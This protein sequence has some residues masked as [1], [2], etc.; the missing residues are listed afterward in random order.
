MNHR[1]RILNV[2]RDALKGAG[3][4]ADDRRLEAAVAN[5]ATVW[6]GDVQFYE[7]DRA[8]LKD[9]IR[10][11]EKLP[12]VRSWLEGRLYTE[13]LDELQ[14]DDTQTH[15][16]VELTRAFALSIHE[17]IRKDEAG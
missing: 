17:R 3:V 11:V 5:I 9:L 2:V 15:N 13:R 4:A 6:W 7:E 12:N 14:A 16:N 8:Q 10:H 1:D